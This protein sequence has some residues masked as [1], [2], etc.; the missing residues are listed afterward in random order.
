M[1]GFSLKH[2]ALRVDVIGAK[3]YTVCRRVRAFF[4]PEI[5]QAGAVIRLILYLASFAVPFGAF[6]FCRAGH[7]QGAAGGRT[8]NLQP[9]QILY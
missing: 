6:S 3:K 9:P 8:Q 1:K 4:S 2:I 7:I 5:L